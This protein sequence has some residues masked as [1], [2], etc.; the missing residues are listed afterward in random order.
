MNLTELGGRVEALR[1]QRGLTLNALAEAASVSISMLS[2]VE[3][4][5]KAPTIVV[6]DRIADG[7]GVPLTELIALPG[8]NRVIVRRAVDQDVLDELGGWQRTILSPVV[9]GVNF[10]WI[11][12]TLPSHCEPEEFPGYAPNSH[13]YIVVEAGTLRL[14]IGDDV[15]DLDS[16][17]SIYFAADVIH[18]YANTTSDPCAYYVAALIMRPRGG[19]R[20]DR[21]Q[22]AI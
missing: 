11:R 2:S 19:R 1:H 5:Q 22:G 8:E 12:S 6:L 13:E 21:V 20:A 7:L 18:R 3:H 10:E 16:G 14:T 9:P 15:F 4:G 17:D